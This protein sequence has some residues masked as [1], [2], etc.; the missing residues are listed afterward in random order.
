MFVGL[1]L[2]SQ[3]F[4]RT[5]DVPPDRRVDLLHIFLLS[6]SIQVY[7]I[8]NG[9]IPRW[10]FVPNDKAYSYRHIVTANTA[11]SLYFDPIIETT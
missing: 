10:L 2:T 1:G 9:G 7:S 8:S 6:S 4:C 11:Q 3:G 5:G